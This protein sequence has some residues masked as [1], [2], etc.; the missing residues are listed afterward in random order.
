[1]SDIQLEVNE[2]GTIILYEITVEVRNLAVK[3]LFNCPPTLGRVCKVVEAIFEQHPDVQTGMVALIL[4]V[5]DNASNTVLD[6]GDMIQFTEDEIPIGFI[7]LETRTLFH[8]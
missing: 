8:G 5:G 2:A 4:S 6:V 1:M 3:M 7:G